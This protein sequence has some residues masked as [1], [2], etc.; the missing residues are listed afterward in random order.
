MPSSQPTLPCVTRQHSQHTAGAAAELHPASQCSLHSCNQNT[1][2]SP[3]TPMICSLKVGLTNL[4]WAV[5]HHHKLQTHPS[6][7][8]NF[9]I[10][11]LRHARP[12]GFH[13]SLHVILCTGTATQGYILIQQQPHGASTLMQS[14]M[15]TL[16]QK[17]EQEG[18]SAQSTSWG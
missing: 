6:Q 13:N 14:C 4:G 11:P 16:G 2:V 7:P 18:G 10:M 1:C 8:A 15:H 3:Q 5:Y 9:T 12:A 17:F